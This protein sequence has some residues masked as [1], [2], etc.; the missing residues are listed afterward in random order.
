MNNVVLDLLDKNNFMIPWNIGNAIRIDKI[1][2]DVS[3]LGFYGV[4][5]RVENIVAMLE[6]IG[7]DINLVIQAEECWQTIAIVLALIARLN[8]NPVL[9]VHTKKSEV[10]DLS[11]FI[12]K[13]GDGP[14]EGHNSIG[15]GE[16]LL[17]TF[18][19][20]KEEKE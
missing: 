18:Q 15:I 11:Y 14:K 19:N 20:L 2:P 6:P 9:L 16:N 8:V 10:M 17:D 7:K 5:M 12:R 13:G 3:S 1:S 4:T